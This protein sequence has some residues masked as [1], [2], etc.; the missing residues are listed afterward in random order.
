[1]W[2]ICHFA[3]KKLGIAANI[4]YCK[5]I[6]FIFL[7]NIM[8]KK[9]LLT[10]AVLASMGAIPLAQAEELAPV[11]DQQA[12]VLPPLE[13]SAAAPAQSSATPTDTRWYVAPF[14]TFIT[15]GSGKADNGW[16]GGLAI[17]KMLDKHFNVE[18]KGFYNTMDYTGRAYDHTRGP[19]LIGSRTSGDWNLAGA[20]VDLQYYFMRDKFSPYTV[21]AVGGMNTDITSTHTRINGVVDERSRSATSFIAE[22]GLGFT[23]EVLDN[24]LVR[25]DVR[26]R[27][28]DTFSN[29]DQVNINGYEHNIDNSKVN[30]DMTVNVGFVIPFGDKPKAAEYVAPAPAPAPVADC[31][32]MDSDA[33]GVNDCVD[34]CP[35]TMA[36]SKVDATG[37][38]V[39]IELHGVNFQFDS[40]KLTPNAMAIL[41]GVAQNLV[42]YPQTDVIE[43]HGYT[44]SEGSN[45][46]NMRLSQARSESV[47]RYLASKGVTNQLIARGYGE[48]NPVASNSTEQGREQNRRVELIWMGH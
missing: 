7:E 41:D 35:G 27:F 5:I 12:N 38:P 8:F 15:T 36:G 19:D 3:L 30:N 28:S 40:A 33:D 26:Y 46:H 16:G 45:A 22:A 13:E 42:S 44:S 25:S 37:C 1:L 9:Q 6:I 47:A 10:L 43:V 4:E 39:K 18:V 29:N 32:T 21:I 20:T 2:L 48:S 17:G 23:Y 24:L 31:S 34:K 11:V 14:G